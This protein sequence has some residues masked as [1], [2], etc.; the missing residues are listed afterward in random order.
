LS[1]KKVFSDTGNNSPRTR[2]SVWSVDC[3]IFAERDEPIAK[4]GPLTFRHR[5]T[6]SQRGETTMPM[7]C[8][9]YELNAEDRKVCTAWLR[10]IIALWSLIGVAVVV[11][12][13]VLAL[14]APV[15]PEQRTA[16]HQ[17]GAYP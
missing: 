8:L 3:E 1:S 12:C 2:K 15:T 5:L 7:Q 10:K 11:V 17:P 9:Y 14:D 4:V 13:T 16:T 6:A